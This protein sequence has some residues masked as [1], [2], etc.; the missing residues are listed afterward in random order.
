M[1]TARMMADKGIFELVQSSKHII[2]ADSDDENEIN[3][4]DPISTP[5]VIMKSMRSYLG[6][7][8]NSKM[9]NKM[10]GIER[11]GDNWILKKTMQGKYQ[12]IFQKLNK[13]F[14]FH[15]T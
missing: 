7:H 5:F 8:S 15:K 13:C 3:N 14:D 11:F 6:A 12:I 2:D 9:N 10:D 4:A 1:D